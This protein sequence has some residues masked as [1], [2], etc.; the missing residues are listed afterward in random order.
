M[1]QQKIK[2]PGV[3]VFL[4]HHLI[5]PGCHLP[6]YIPQPVTGTVFPEFA[7]LAAAFP[8]GGDYTVFAFYGGFGEPDRCQLPLGRQE[9]KFAAYTGGK[10]K[11]PEMKIIRD[12]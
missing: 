4:D 7:D 5:R 1:K 10:L 8:V 3:F 6:V 9:G 2:I 12:I 11:G